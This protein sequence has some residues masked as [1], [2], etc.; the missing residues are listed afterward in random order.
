MCNVLFVL[1]GLRRLVLPVDPEL[2]VDRFS[3]LEVLL[4]LL[5]GGAVGGAVGGAALLCMH[6]LLCNTCC[7]ARHAAALS[8][9]AVLSTD[10]V[11][12]Q[13]AVVLGCLA[14]VVQHL[15]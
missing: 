9:A 1:S 15:V 7:S 8:T 13:Y 12:R 11:W 10:A 6:G 3:V 2:L 14:A 5:A 4:V